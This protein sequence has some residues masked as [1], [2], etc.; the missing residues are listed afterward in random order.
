MSFIILSDVGEIS[1]TKQK[2]Q[3]VSLLEKYELHGNSWGV[4]GDTKSLVHFTFSVPPPFDNRLYFGKNIIFLTW[5]STMKQRDITLDMFTKMWEQSLQKG[6]KR[7]GVISFK[8]Q[9]TGRPLRPPAKKRNEKKKES[10]ETTQDAKKNGDPE[11][12]DESG[13][14]QKSLK[15]ENSTKDNYTYEECYDEE[16][17]QDTD[18]ELS[19]L[20][21]NVDDFQELEEELEEDLEEDEDLE[22]LEEDE[23]ED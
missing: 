15:H 3:D 4:L 6:F 10:E 18:S 5:D 13:D 8:K 22:E 12:E 1:V 11:A 7:L 16:F 21:E 20:S 14:D 23:D 19:E 9:V 17:V 2:P